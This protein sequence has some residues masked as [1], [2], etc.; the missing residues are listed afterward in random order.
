MS[1]SQG[2]IDWIKGMLLRSPWVLVL[3]AQE[4][5]FRRSSRVIEGPCIKLKR[6][7]S[8]MAVFG[9]KGISPRNHPFLNKSNFTEKFYSMVILK[10]ISPRNHPFKVLS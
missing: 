9:V 8:G 4:E 1:K 7:L 3:L 10:V 6:K 2:E 5:A